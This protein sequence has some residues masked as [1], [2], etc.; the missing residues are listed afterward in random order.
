MTINKPSRF[1]IMVKILQGPSYYNAKQTLADLY[2]QKT[3]T[4]TY[5][6]LRQ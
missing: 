3:Y 2:K 6:V 5:T 1:I 4:I